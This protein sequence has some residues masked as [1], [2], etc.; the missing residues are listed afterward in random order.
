LALLA[1]TGGCDR[2]EQAH[3]VHL[4]KG[5]YAG[6]PMTKLDAAQIT[7]LER[8]AANENY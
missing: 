8:R 4:Q 7:A 3:E 5:A 1:A 2:A 6:K